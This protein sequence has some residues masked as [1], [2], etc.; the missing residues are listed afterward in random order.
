MDDW[1]EWLADFQPIKNKDNNELLSQLISP[2]MKTSF[3]NFLRIS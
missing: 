2:N 1:L 3:Y